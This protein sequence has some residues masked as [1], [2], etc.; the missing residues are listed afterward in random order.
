[1]PAPVVPAADPV[2]LPQKL[3]LQQ[4]LRKGTQR[5]NRRKIDQ[6]G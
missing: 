3:G 6:I 2:P 4:P 5:S 1:L